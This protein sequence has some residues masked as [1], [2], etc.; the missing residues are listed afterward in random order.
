MK[1]R[2]Y[3]I[4]GSLMV[5]LATI[6]CEKEELIKDRDYPRLSI[7]ATIIQNESGATFEGIILSEAGEIQDKG[8]VWDEGSVASINTGSSI[9]LGPGYEDGRFIGTAVFD[10]EAEKE[11]QVKAFVLSEDR[12][13]YST[14]VAFTSKSDGLP[15]SLV[16]FSPHSGQ[17]GDT[18]LITG[19]YLS[20]QAERISVYFNNTS[21]NIL[22]CTDTTIM[23]TVPVSLNDNESNIRVV[24]Q[25][26]QKS[27]SEAFTLSDPVIDNIHP[28]LVT[29]PGEQI[30]I[31]GSGFST[32]KENNLV[33]LGTLSAQ[34]SSATATNLKVVIP[35]SLVPDPDVSIDT[36]VSVKVTFGGKTAISPDSLRLDYKA[37]WTRMND[38]PGDPRKLALSFGDGS[39]GFYGL[40]SSL[41]GSQ[42]F[43]DLWEYNP[44][45][46]S[47]TDRSSFPGA[48]RNYF[49]TFTLDNILYL[50][51]GSTGDP[52]IMANH[53][54]ENWS[55]NIDTDQW[56]RLNDFVGTARI[57]AGGFA[58]AGKG[59]R[60]SGCHEN[61]TMNL[62][63]WEYLPGSDTWTRKSDLTNVEPMTHE[64]FLLSAYGNGESGLIL[65]KARPRY[66]NPDSWIYHPASDSWTGCG[67][68][69]TYEGSPTGCYI[70]DLLYM[71]PTYYQGLSEYAR[72]YTYNADGNNWSYLYDSKSPSRRDAGSFSIDDKY[73]FFG[74][75]D[76][77][78]E[79]LLNDVWMLDFNR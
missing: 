55:Y 22:S 3:I 75:L 20:Y 29:N 63:V 36:T 59:F 2:T 66:T 65:C 68:P 17:L 51:G 35:A 34:V 32:L 64:Q 61:D 46:D 52:S 70:G 76:G 13:I 50:V 21:A 10:L 8:F 48:P 25:E 7:G 79:V 77:S 1:S 78:G 45:N 33:K 37:L 60:V 56:T 53:S 14:P 9:L 23:V 62:E 54:L 5:I 19:I 49:S 58:A 42:F 47:W 31:S 24:I 12:T 69:G 26:S 30:T 6:G 11:Y 40:G 43:T 39:R 67:F 18:V 41:V 71:G 28:A 57:R 4:L 44:G 27:F 16:S 15:H 74:G 72:I 38:L 73:Y